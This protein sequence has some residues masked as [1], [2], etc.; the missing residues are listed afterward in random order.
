MTDR[1]EI[2]ADLIPYSEEYAQS[3]RKWIETEETYQ[4]VSRGTEFPP[5][6][7]IITSWQR[8][9]MASYLLT[10]EN[11]PIAYGE[12]WN[13]PNEFTVEIAH[14]LVDQFRRGEGYGVK[15][16][17]LLYNRAAARIDVSKVT[18]IVNSDNESALRCFMKAGFELAGTTN[19]T[20]GLKLIKLV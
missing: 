2:K 5:P 8:E 3:I 1:I 11:R 7:N 14:L 10:F 15:L 19:Y 18:A 20:K 13:R 17:N 9:G 16:I 12:L 6:D 4:F